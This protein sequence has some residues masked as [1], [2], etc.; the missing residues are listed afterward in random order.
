M[1]TQFNLPHTIVDAPKD[2]IV[3]GRSTETTPATAAQDIP[4]LWQRVISEGLGPNGLAGAEVHQIYA[5][6]CDYRS[7]ARGPYTMVLGHAVGP[8]VEVPPGLRRVRIP[9]GRYLE[10][11]LEGDPR[12]VVWQAWSAINDPTHPLR[13]RRYIA[14]YEC[15]PVAS[16][17]PDFA[18]VQLR[19]GLADE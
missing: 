17:R 9:A 2:L 11:D 1:Q 8:E 7:D 16:L 12:Q 15:Y 19:V 18:A 14:D 3:I 4:A 6:Y 10:L 5:V 13:P